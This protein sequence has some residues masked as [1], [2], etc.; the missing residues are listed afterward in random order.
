MTTLLLRN[1]GL[2]VTMDDAGNELSHVSILVQDGWIASISTDAPD[3]DEVIDCSRSLVIP[4]LVNT[5]HHLYQTLTRGFSQSEGLSLFHWLRMLYPIWAGLDEA[6]IY[7]SARTGL[8]ELALSGCTTCADHLYLF[9][10]GSENF[11]DAEIAAA[12]SLGVRFHATR[13]S[14]DL[15]VEDGGLPPRSVVQSL[16]VI[17][18]DSERVVRR[19]HDAAPGA[20]VQVGIAPCSPFSASASLMKESA[21][22]ARSLGVRLHTHIAETLDEDR[23]SRE[24]CGQSPIG[25]LESLDWIG[26]D[27]WV[28]HCV[29]PMDGDLAVLQRGPVGVAH[30]PTS[31]MLLGSG[32]APISQF[33]Q[34]GIPVGLGVD[35]SASNDGNDLKN[36]VKQAVLSAR[37]SA[38]PGGLSVRAALRIAT[39]GGAACLGRDDI[40][41]LQP[42]K[43]ADLAMFDLDSLAMAGGAQDAVALAVLGAARPLHVFVHGRSVVRDGILVQ[44]DG[45][46]IAVEQNRAAERLMARS[47][48]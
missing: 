14:M 5:H 26:P 17:L 36:E 2:V 20:M 15:S 42:G 22:L 45:R 44:T 48:G 9:P 4:G 6:M 3:A 46:D 13:G 33:L 43:C 35:G 28:A 47:G 12:A 40:G 16:D 27:V 18:A 30:C 23:Y 25:L 7:A 10:S 31:N 41:S 21:A 32:I 24:L 38:G 29:H 19:Y 1:C 11:I 8:A 37:A 34:V 39:R